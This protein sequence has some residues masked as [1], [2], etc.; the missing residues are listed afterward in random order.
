M[1]A[2]IISFEDIVFHI[3]QH[4]TQKIAQMVNE[5]IFEPYLR[6]LVDWYAL[7][8]TRVSSEQLHWALIAAQQTF[9]HCFHIVASQQRVVLLFDSVNSLEQPSALT[10][11]IELLLQVEN[12]VVLLCGSDMEALVGSWQEHVREPIQI[13]D[14]A[15]LSAEAGTRYIHYRQ[16]QLRAV[17]S[18][19][20]EANVLLFTRGHPVLIDMATTW[21][22]RNETPAWLQAISVDQLRLL[23]E[24]ELELYRQRFE[25]VLVRYFVQSE[26][27]MGRL[28]MLMAHV[29]R[30]DAKLTTMLLRLLEREAQMLLRTASD[31]VF[32]RSFS[33]QTLTLH[34]EMQ[35]LINTYLWPVIDPDGSQR[36]RQSHI[37]AAYQSEMIQILGQQIALMSEQENQN[38]SNHTIP[39]TH[40]MPLLAQRETLEYE[41]MLRRK[42]Q[43]THTLLADREQG[44]AVFA[45]MFDT[46]FCEKR[47]D[48]RK[49]IIDQ[50]QVYA[51]TLNQQQ[52]YTLESRHIEWL[53][54]GGSYQQ[55]YDRASH[56]LLNEHAEPAHRVALLLQC[57]NAALRLGHWQRGIADFEQ[58][59]EISTN[60]HLR[61]WLARSLNAR[62][63]VHRQQGLYQ[64]AMQDYLAAY[65]HHLELYETDQIAL[66]LNNI[67]FVNALNGN[68]ESALESCR[69]ALDLWDLSP[70]QC[71]RA[72]TYST[73]GG[74]YVR[75]DQ[76]TEAMTFYN[77]ALDL[78]SN[79]GDV[80]WM[81]LVRCGRAFAFQSRGE[82]ERAADDLDWAWRYGGVHLQPR[83]LSSQALIKWANHDLAGA[84]LTLE[85]CRQISQEQGDTFHD[86]KSFTDL[87]ELAWEF[88]EYDRWSAF[89]EEHQQRYQ[90]QQQQ[91]TMMLRLQGS[92]LRKIA[93]LALCHGSYEAALQAYQEGFLLIA[94]HEVYTRYTMRSQLRQTEERL[95]GVV[96]QTRLQQL[97]RDMTRFWSEHELF[98]MYYP[99]ALLTF[100]RW[101]N[102]GSIGTYEPAANQSI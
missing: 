35:R 69:A 12:V 100:Q 74:I 61:S 81:S 49:V 96:P 6:V 58:A 66:T 38:A 51:Q 102:E 50:V 71:G 5:R 92:C 85:Q 72:A 56:L 43:L 1:V 65:Q 53:L 48:F 10:G 39:I 94:S 64:R 78:L 88:G 73:L 7:K 40:G 95:H 91:G 97:G 45:D 25:S 86:Y 87:L 14:L 30:V 3:P 46:V 15:L 70:D 90:D 33:D 22:L 26:H 57:G 60:N 4:I 83:I 23:P 89:W 37:T 16:D 17:L 98:L 68:R 41:Q 11:L 62:G 31:Y 18:P 101:Q 84:R 28:L 76:P 13:I 36:R 34:E 47:Q 32:V 55:A 9:V 19:E 2:S 21:L 44:L 80:G 54:R 8:H 63:W 20:L 75:F 59:I 93:D 99:E 27:L 29:G 77:R 52:R 82:L 79:E 42:E 67:A 24:S